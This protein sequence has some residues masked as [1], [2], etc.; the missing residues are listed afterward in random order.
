MFLSSR[1]TVFSSADTVL[2]RY[3]C[4]DAAIPSRAGASYARP[5]LAHS[6]RSRSRFMAASRAPE[7]ASQ[8]LLS[9]GLRRLLVNACYWAV[10]LEDR[11][12]AESKVDLVG[13]Y[14]PLPFGNNKFKK[15]VTPSDLARW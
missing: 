7:G 1:Q 14:H 3:S 15:G 12:P 13:E 11:I 4:R 8:D 5:V 6:S 9:A 2:W 10:G